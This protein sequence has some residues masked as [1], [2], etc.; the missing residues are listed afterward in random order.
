[1]PLTPHILCIMG[2]KFLLLCHIHR[3]PMYNVVGISDTQARPRYGYAM[4]GFVADGV[5]ISFFKL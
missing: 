4:S 3:Y 2:L 1:M 5:V